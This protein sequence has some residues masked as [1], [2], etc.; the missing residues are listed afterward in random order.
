MMRIGI[1]AQAATGQLTGL[2]TY[3][4]HLIAALTGQS[5]IPAVFTK[6]PFE[7]HFYADERYGTNTPSRIYWENWVLPQRI[8]KDGLQLLHV[9]AFAPAM[10]PRMKTV[11]TAHDLIGMLFP[12]QI[13]RASRFYWGRW[14]PAA[15]KRADALIADSESTRRDLIEHLRV[16]ERKITVIYPSGHEGFTASVSAQMLAQVKTKHGLDT[17]YFLFVGTIEPRKNLSRVIGAVERLKKSGKAGGA[18]LVVVGSKQ[19]AHGAFFQQLGKSMSGA[20]DEIIFTGY[21]TRA[22]LNSLYCGAAAL[23]YPSLYEGFGIPI[24]EALGSGCPVIT[25]NVSSTPEVAGEAALQ[26]D[27]LDESQ[28]A[29]AM[30][31]MLSDASLRQKLKRA[32]AEQIKKFSWEKTAQQTLQVYKTLLV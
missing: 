2:G 20:M 13:G 9:P 17:P 28:I 1:D 12:N 14:L 21:V 5:E 10:F 8:K 11:V 32:G 15:L 26:V 19:F 22:E 31:R 25:A 6:P 3:T 29:A 4:K 7:F 18:R 16:P 24:L 27:P 30:E 23:V